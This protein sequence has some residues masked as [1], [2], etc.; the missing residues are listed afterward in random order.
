[1]D[2]TFNIKKIS[3]IINFAIIVIPIIKNYIK[4]KNKNK[5]KKTIKKDVIIIILL[6]ITKINYI[7]NPNKIKAICQFPKPTLILGKLI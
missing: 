3:N 7:V 2:V 1:M 5:R 6:I 4:N